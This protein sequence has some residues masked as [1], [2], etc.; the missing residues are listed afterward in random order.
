MNNRSKLLLVLLAALILFY[1]VFVEHVFDAVSF[2]NGLEKIEG[3][4][5]AF[6][7]KGLVPQGEKELK[8]YNFELTN[9]ER[10]FS[11][12]KQ[13][14]DAKALSLLVKTRKELVLMQLNLIEVQK[15]LSCAEQV[16]AMDSVISSA[17]AARESIQEYE[18]YSF[19]EETKE[20]NENVL[21][22]TSSIITSFRELK[23]L[24]GS[25]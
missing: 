5:T 6:V 18:G 12:K 23:D 3:I 15:A 8:E 1:F 13:N 7:E 24:K 10:E 9:L 2:S 20:W 4:D 16:E 21:D 14:Q 11:E 19:A 22:T 17:E 25:C